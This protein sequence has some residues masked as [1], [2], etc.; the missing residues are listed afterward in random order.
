MQQHLIWLQ[1]NKVF[2][3]FFHDGAKPFKTLDQVAVRTQL[4]E[5]KNRIGHELSA[6]HF[7]WFS[8]AKALS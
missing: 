5:K 1:R 4:R 2:R 7:L 6:R 3:Q 8:N